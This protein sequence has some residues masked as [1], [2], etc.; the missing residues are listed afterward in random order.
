MRQKHRNM[1][2]RVV[3]SMSNQWDDPQSRIQ[4][5]FNNVDYLHLIE[6]TRRIAVPLHKYNFDQLMQNEFSKIEE[7]KFTFTSI[8]K[9]KYIRYKEYRGRDSRWDK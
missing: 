5:I 7:P 8:Y 2:L 3:F 6:T 1:T 4:Y 9:Y